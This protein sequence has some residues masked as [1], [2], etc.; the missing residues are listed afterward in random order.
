MIQLIWLS[1]SPLANIIMKISGINWC[2]LRQFVSLKNGLL[3]CVCEKQIIVMR[4]ILSI[5]SHDSV[6]LIIIFAIGE[7]YYEN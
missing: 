4:I 2:A 3:L 7:Y 1:F 5:N 6:D